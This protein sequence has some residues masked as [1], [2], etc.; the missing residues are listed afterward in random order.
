[1]WSS[2][3]AVL[4]VAFIVGILLLGVAIL[5]PGIVGGGQLYA[6]KE[7]PGPEGM[8][9]SV[10]AGDGCRAYVGEGVR[11]AGRCLADAETA[12]TLLY[13]WDFGDGTVEQGNLTPYHRYAREGTYTVTL[14]V[15]DTNG[16][17]RSDT[18][19]VIVE[20][21]PEQEDPGKDPEVTPSPAA[22]AGATPT[23]GP[24][25][26]ATAT[27][28]PA[29]TRSTSSGDDETDM[30]CDF[31]ASVRE[32]SAPLTVQF[33]DTSPAVA[34]TWSW[35]FG[36]GATS[37]EQNP[38]HVYAIPGSYSVYLHIEDEGGERYG[39]IKN[40]YITVTEP[41]A[42]PQ[43]EFSADTTAGEAPLTV[44]FTDLSGGSPTSWA[45]EFGDGG[46]S[47]D[48]NPT[49][50]YIMSGTYTVTLTAG[51]EFG[52][53]AQTREGYITV[54]APA[55]PP[56]EPTAPPTEEPTVE[57]T[58]E[59]TVEPTEEPTVEPTE[60]PNDDDDDDDGDDDDDDDDDR[61]RDDDDED[62]DDDDD[63]W[64]DDRRRDDRRR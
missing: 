32:G 28:T 47:A 30:L 63:R 60:E 8:L 34:D 2:R 43:T 37:T 25:P 53:I 3:R 56:T 22:T 33:S 16:N 59:P 58:E 26:T 9:A 61:W 24:T 36:D 45:W 6:Q 44:S 14:T 39:E 31:R 18:A 11:F 54:T 49:H 51:N 29:P 13:T 5:I 12:D 52:S 4:G 38:T 1:M 21:V 55:P 46:A 10:S 50:E 27:R 20:P 19:D 40:G 15:T 7:M 64:R 41:P 35:G 48:R 42:P 62:D 57:P 17:T 23:P